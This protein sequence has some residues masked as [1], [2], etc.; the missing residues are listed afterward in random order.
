MAST[1]SS[2]RVR[3]LCNDTQGD[4]ELKA[5]RLEPS[6]LH[7][8]HHV[9]FD[10][11]DLVFKEVRSVVHETREECQRVFLSIFKGCTLVVDSPDLLELFVIL[12]KHLCCVSLTFVL[13]EGPFRAQIAGCSQP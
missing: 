8:R 4:G 3:D 2:F 7:A 12:V 13:N 1:V 11:F 10:V 5:V 9:V 6:L